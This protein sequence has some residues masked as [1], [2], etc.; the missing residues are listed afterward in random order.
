MVSKYV[1]TINNTPYW[2]KDVEEKAAT[3]GISVEE[4]MYRDAVWMYE[5]NDKRKID[6]A[7][8]LLIGK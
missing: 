2:R 1:K 7:N 3:R 5:N 6:E 8:A 4:M